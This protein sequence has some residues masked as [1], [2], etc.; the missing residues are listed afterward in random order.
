MFVAVQ[1]WVQDRLGLKLPLLDG[2]FCLV[3]S[4]ALTALAPAAA[5]AIPWRLRQ[6]AAIEPGPV[7]GYPESAVVVL[8][9]GARVA[10][11]EYKNQN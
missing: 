2:A 5:A 6:I 3:P 10:A 7:G 4:T 11:G 9:G 1:Q 8:V